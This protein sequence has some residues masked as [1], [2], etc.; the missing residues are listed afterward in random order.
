M[1]VLL[2]QARRSGKW[3]R[4]STGQFTTTCS[5]N[6]DSTITGVLPFVCGR[7]LPPIGGAATNEAKEWRRDC[8][9]LPGI[10]DT[11]VAGGRGRS[12]G[13]ARP[14]VRGAANSGGYLLGRG[15]AVA[16]G[17]RAPARATH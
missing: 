6:P 13:T 11:A 7:G 14:L 4:A 17:C 15:A 10:L 16:G 9:G 5:P 12:T 3:E 2:A 8:R 1:I